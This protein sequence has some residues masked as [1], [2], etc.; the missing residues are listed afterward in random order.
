MRKILYI[1]GELEDADLQWLI[2]AGTVR[3]IDAGTPVI[4][5][6]DALDDLFIVIDGE[7]VVST[8]GSE[9]ARL[10]SGEVMGEMSLLDSRPPNA[11]VTAGRDST[12]F[13]IP[14][15]ALRSKLAGDPGFAAHFYRAICTF[16]ANRLGRT[17]QLVGAT[18]PAT[19][20]GNSDGD[21][22]SPEAL[23]TVALAGARFDWFLQRVRGG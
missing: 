16:L 14:Q 9:L 15:A 13:S 1:L 23:E 12:V 21:E 22:L 17:G 4:S 3:A 8:A 6:G 20:S 2:D 11:T 10:S 7:F 19:Q 18:A 5:E